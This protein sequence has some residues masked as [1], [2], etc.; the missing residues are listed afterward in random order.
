MGVSEL[1]VK[2][3]GLY[4]MYI[5]FH[6][7]PVAFSRVS[8]EFDLRVALKSTAL[9]TTLNKQ[10]QYFRRHEEGWRMLRRIYHLTYKRTVGAL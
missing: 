10:Q 1:G 3:L 5:G 7:F 4:R 9:V 8:A 6:P 2:R